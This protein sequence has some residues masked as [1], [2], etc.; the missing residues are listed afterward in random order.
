MFWAFTV[1]QVG[2]LPLDPQEYLVRQVPDFML[3][4]RMA[5]EALRRQPGASG[6]AAWICRARHHFRPNSRAG[7]SW[8]GL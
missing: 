8:V 2:K 6:H 7:Q 1:C 5:T 3:L 4:H